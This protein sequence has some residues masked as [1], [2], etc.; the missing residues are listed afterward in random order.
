MKEREVQRPSN[1]EIDHRLKEAKEA[2]AND[3]ASFS[4][5]NK[6]VGEL[7]ELG[8]GESNEVWALIRSLLDE[9]I[10]DNYT[11][12]YPP[13]V[14]YEPVGNGLDLWAFCW[15][16][17]LLNKKMYLKFSIANGRFY[18]VSLHRSKK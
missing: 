14:N 13:L 6:V 18:Y 17:T 11:G 4:N 9:I 3:C 2:L 1:R 5:P 8:I 10:I 15:H 16:S 7:M 12:G